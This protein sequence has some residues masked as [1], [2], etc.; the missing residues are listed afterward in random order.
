MKKRTKL[1]TGIV[2][3]CILAAMATIA[4]A[5]FLIKTVND[6]VLLL[7]EEATWT[8][9]NYPAWFQVGPDGI[10]EGVITIDGEETAFCVRYRT[11]YAVF[12]DCTA[13]ETCAPDSDDYLLI[14]SSIRAKFG[15]LYVSVTED[16]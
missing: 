13:R 9:T 4:G 6:A 16:V 10:A 5:G 3:F 14:E 11:G 2:L 7:R 1:I 8:C 12:F 15:R